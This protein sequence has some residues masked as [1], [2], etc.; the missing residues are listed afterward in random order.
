ATQVE[1]LL[2]LVP[3]L[4]AMGKEVRVEIR[5]WI[6]EPEP[7]L[8]TSCM[9]Y[10]TPWATSGLI[11]SRQLT[12]WAGSWAPVASVTESMAIGSQYLPSLAKVANALA[13][14]SGAVWVAPMRLES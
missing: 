11:A 13:M 8:S 12:V 14:V 4:A 6:S 2:S 10:A 1:L 7:R 9:A 5:G 3:V